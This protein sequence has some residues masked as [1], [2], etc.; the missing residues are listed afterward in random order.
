MDKKGISTDMISLLICLPFF[1]AVNN[2]GGEPD[3]TGPPVFNSTAAVEQFQPADQSVDASLS[4][5]SPTADAAL[6]PADPEA[7]TLTMPPYPEARSAGSAEESSSVT[8]RR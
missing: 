2:S 1:F 4:L 3:N 5:A 6:S 8:P 7:D